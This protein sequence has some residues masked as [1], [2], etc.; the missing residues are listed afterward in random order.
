MYAYEGSI[1]EMSGHDDFWH[2]A[3]DPFF[4]KTVCVDTEYARPIRFQMDSE[5]AY[6]EWLKYDY[7]NITFSAYSPTLFQVDSEILYIVIG[8]LDPA[9]LEQSS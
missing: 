8:L 2:V 5:E 9:Q 7:R 1:I 3:S 6:R 4:D